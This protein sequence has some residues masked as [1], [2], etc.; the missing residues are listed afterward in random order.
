MTNI[1]DRLDRLHAKLDEIIGKRVPGD[2]DGD[3]ITNESRKKP[4]GYS[5]KNPGQNAL[6]RQINTTLRR[7]MAPEER[8]A[9]DRASAQ[10]MS[11]GHKMAQSIASDLIS[12]TVRADFKGMK[13]T[14]D[15]ATGLLHSGNDGESKRVRSRLAVASQLART[16]SAMNPNYSFTASEM[17][18][19]GRAVR[20]DV[21]FDSRGELVSAKPKNSP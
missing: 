4:K 2:G 5:Y 7:E 11:R 10:N 16:Y 18:T 9:V 6:A 20:G 12:G 3:G 17:R 14:L 19:I 1:R 21:T 8:R 13:D 15:T